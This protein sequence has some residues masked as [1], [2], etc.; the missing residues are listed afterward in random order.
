ME[1]Q[2]NNNSTTNF[3]DEE[4]SSYEVTRWRELSTVTLEKFRDILQND[5]IAKSFDEDYVKCVADR[6]RDI[7]K[8]QIKLEV[9]IFLIIIIMG[10]IDSGVVRQIG[11]FGITLS[12]EKSALSI[13]LFLS[14]I[15]I[16]FSSLASLMVDHYQ[17]VIRSF[18]DVRKDSQIREY[19]LLK[20]IWSLSALIE[21]F[22][23]ENQKITPN[24]LVWVLV[25]LFVSLLILVAAIVTVLEWF[26]FVSSI[27]SVYQNSIFPAVINVPILVIAICAVL[28]RIAKFFLTLPL[29]HTDD[30]NVEKLQK[31]E[32][33]DPERAD[34]I[35]TNIAI[36]SLRK[37]RRNVI[38]SQFS[39]V[40]FSFVFFYLVLYGTS[41]FSD[42]SIL[43]SLAPVLLIFVVLVSPLLDVYERRVILSTTNIKDTDSKV[44]I[45]VRDKKR[46]F[47]VRLMTSFAFSVIS[48]ACFELIK[49]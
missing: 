13:L 26:I 21:G 34:R 18:V 33:E 49:F 39:I 17:A 20:Y 38:I 6:W 46:I 8:I 12:M 23:F 5:E 11:F 41:L 2:Q 44:K 4:F 14:S 15:L 43:M 3:E 35:R 10:A 16:A 27:F 48:F 28:L 45:Y 19:Y 31:I 36:A 47:K 24:R 7:L 40:I 30:S 25:V 9:T 32:Q 22:A 37:E 29:P 1:H 42:Y